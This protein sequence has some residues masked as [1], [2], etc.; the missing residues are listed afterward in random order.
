MMDFCK[1]FAKRFADTLPAALRDIAYHLVP[2]TKT[3]IRRLAFG[4]GVRT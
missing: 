1:K 2:P 4:I 3:D